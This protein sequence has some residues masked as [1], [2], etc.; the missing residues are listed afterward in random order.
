MTFYHRGTHDPMLIGLEC[1]L[2]VAD[3]LQFYLS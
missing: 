3:Q 1:D 2:C